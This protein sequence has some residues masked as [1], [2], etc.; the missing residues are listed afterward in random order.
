[1]ARSVRLSALLERFEILKDTVDLKENS[2]VE[3]DSIISTLTEKIIAPVLSIDNDTGCKLWEYV[4]KKYYDHVH[5]VDFTHLAE[6]VI[7]NAEY[8]ALVEAF[9]KNDCICKYVFKLDPYENH[10]SCEWFIRDLILRNEFELAEKLTQLFFENDKGKNDPQN[11]LHEL[12]YQILNSGESRWQMSSDGIDFVAKWIPKVDS[13]TKRAQLEACL[14]DLIEC[15]EN[16]APKGAMPF[17]LFAQE[18]GLELLIKE[19][20]KQNDVPTTSKPYNSFEEYMEQRRQ[21]KDIDNEIQEAQKEFKG[22]F[23]YDILKEC[24]DELFALIGLDDVKSEITSL[25]NLAQICRL[26]KEKGLAVPEI[27]MHMVF[28]GNPGT[29]KT[30]VA[31]IIGKIYHALGILS[32]GHFIEADRSSLVAGYVGQTAIKTKE[33]MNQAKGGVLFI[34]EAY[35]LYKE[36]DNDFGREAVETLLKT[37]EDW[38]NDLVVIVAGYPELMTEFINSN[39]G[40]KS[41]F[42]KIIH[43]PNYTGK[44]LLSIFELLLEKNQYFMS[45]EAKALASQHFIE[46]YNNRGKNFGNGRDIRNFFE[47]LVSV[48]ADRLINCGD[49]SEK[50]LTEFTIL[51]I[52]AAIRDNTK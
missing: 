43:F 18:G 35:S 1:M 45:I 40:L 20:Q 3:T 30:T 8:S 22:L 46:L 38:R 42:S 13:E 25:T 7:D 26:R 41:R 50:A 52:A 10:L 34:D 27:S 2:N 44:E 29:G 4:L 11:N 9:S 49:T 28:T 37:M 39:P 19:K 6:L 5:P 15:V 48:Q 16:D 32:K 33:V 31:R 12:L 14:I 24:Q 17:S 51:D 36:N 23:D 21:S 47:K